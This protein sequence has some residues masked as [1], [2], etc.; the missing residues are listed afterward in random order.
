[1]CLA[2]DHYSYSQGFPLPHG[3]VDVTVTVL[4]SRA[5]A[6]R[7]AHQYPPHHGRHPAHALGP[8]E[9]INDG[10]CACP[11]YQGFQYGLQMTYRNLVLTVTYNGYDGRERRALAHD[12]VALI[13]DYA[14]QVLVR[15]RAYART[16][17]HDR[18]PAWAW[19]QR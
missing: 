15:T 10:T 16:H 3:I 8:D 1:M 19:D 14:A 17:T 12:A 18:W 2:P 5:S 13:T 9:L 11:G 6:R 7:L 4:R